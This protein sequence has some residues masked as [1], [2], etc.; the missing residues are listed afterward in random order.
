MDSCRD[1][2]IRIG[3]H[4]DGAVHRRTSLIYEGLL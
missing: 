4:L 3:E 2:V 1:W